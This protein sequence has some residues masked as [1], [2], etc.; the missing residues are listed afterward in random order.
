MIKKFIE[1]LKST[2][3]LSPKTLEAYSIDLKTFLQVEKNLLEP[4]IRAYVL[5]L[6]SLGL[7]DSSVKRKIVTLR[8]FYDY[9]YNEKI[10]SY[11]PFFNLKFKFRQERKLPKTLSI[12][13]VRRLLDCFICESEN[14]T[15]FS[16]RL[17]VR[18]CAL[19]DLLI[20]TGIRVAEAAAIRFDDIITYE[21]AVLIHG[22]G[23][24]QRIIYISSS[25]TWQRLMTQ[26]RMQKKLSS[27]SFLFTNRNDKPLT[28][29]SIEKIYRKYANVAKI[30]PVSTPHYLRHTF[31]D[32]YRSKFSTQKTSVEK[33]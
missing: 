4:D 3:N 26:F 7:K 28:S 24:K 22:K 19:I 1:Y 25:E 21:H 31:S 17:F 27:T 18:D 15:D 2:K 13:E 11:S 23:R 5:H 29:H 6:Q 10:I 33:I 16:H 12:S 30:N 32:I 8:I 9:L 14:I 20:S